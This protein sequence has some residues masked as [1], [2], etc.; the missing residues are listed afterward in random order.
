MRC[1][2]SLA[3]K[4]F[5]PRRCF[6]MNLIVT[7]LS[8]PQGLQPFAP[9]SVS[10]LSF[11]LA[12]F[13]VGLRGASL[14]STIGC[15]CIYH[16]LLVYS[17]HFLVVLNKLIDNVFY[18]AFFLVPTRSTLSKVS[19]LS[20]IPT[21]MLRGNITPLVK[22]RDGDLS[23]SSNYR[24]ITLSLIFVQMYERLQKAK[25]GYFLP[26]SDSQFGF[27]SGISTSHAIFTLK[28]SVDFFTANNSNVF[29]AFL[30]CS[31][32]FD[33]ISHW[34]L[35]LKLIQCNVPLCFLLS[36]MFLYLNMS[37][38][39]KWNDEKSWRNFRR[40]KCRRR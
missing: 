11:L 36:V 30:D 32:A 34:G 1:F 21:M 38:T 18:K 14:S 10:S 5:H 16:L 2:S 31:K 29:L 4:V 7:L 17:L 13:V 3:V 8:F 33:R 35:F 25:F 26:K 20:F 27:R 39:V 6:I 9:V 37:C 19:C 40:S 23:D 12:H 24:P 28:K 15:V 22:D